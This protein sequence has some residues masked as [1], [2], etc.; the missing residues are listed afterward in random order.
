MTPMTENEKKEE[1]TPTQTETQDNG[2][3]CIENLHL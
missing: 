3:C 1:P 2:L